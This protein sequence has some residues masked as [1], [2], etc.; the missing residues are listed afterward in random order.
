MSTVCCNSF[1]FEGKKAL[2]D[3]MSD[4]PNVSAHRMGRILLGRQSKIWLKI[5]FISIVPR[6]G[7][8]NHVYFFVYW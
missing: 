5:D 2:G 3:N 4:V 6:R 8:I 1:L 7:L